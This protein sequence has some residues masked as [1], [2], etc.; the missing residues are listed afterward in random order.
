VV[1]APRASGRRSPRSLIQVRGRGFAGYASTTDRTG[2]VIPVVVVVV[3]MVMVMV[4]A[5]ARAQVWPRRIG[6]SWRVLAKGI[7]M[8]VKRTR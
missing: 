3:V 7:D 6:E 1:E 8:G 5:S 2:P 4:V